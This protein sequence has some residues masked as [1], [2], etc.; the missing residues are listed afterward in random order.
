ME[1]YSSP[2]PARTHEMSLLRGAMPKPDSR[3]GRSVFDEL[4][5]PARGKPQ[6]FQTQ[7]RRN[8]IMAKLIYKISQEA[9]EDILRSRYSHFDALVRNFGCQITAL[10]NFRIFNKKGLWDEARRVHEKASECIQKIDSF[11]PKPPQGSNGM[12]FNDY[13]KQLDVDIQMSPE[14]LQ[15]VRFKILNIVN[16]NVLFNGREL[17]K[18]NTDSLYR[19]CNEIAAEFNDKYR[20]QAHK[21]PTCIASWI[22]G[23]QA[24]EAEAA[25]PFIQKVGSELIDSRRDLIQRMLGEQHKRISTV[26][27]SSSTPIVSLPQLYTGEAALKGVNGIVLVKNKM[28]LC[29]VPIASAE[30]LQAYVKMPENRV[31]KPTEVAEIPN[32]EPI[33]VLEGYIPK[34]TNLEERVES[35]GLATLL[36]ATLA[37]LPQYASGTDNA[38]FDD[39][40]A[41]K[42]LENFQTDPAFEVIDVDHMYCASMGEERKRALAFRKEGKT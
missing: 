33:V 5:L 20:Y 27:G 2:V 25:I 6:G 34:K 39:A 38:P 15:M 36:N 11:W 35:I 26:R 21:I 37:R 28:L 4:R 32:D 9:A 31:L 8:L 13:L 22:A 17:P 40:E 24:E 16:T 3:E 18:T 12:E 19:R 29:G 41:E 7:C 42:D 14:M 1:P 10:Q 23:L 30:A